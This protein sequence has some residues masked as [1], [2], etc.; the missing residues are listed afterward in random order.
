RLSNKQYTRPWFCKKCEQAIGKTEAEAARLCTRIEE[1][2]KG[3]QVYGESL[4]R[5]ATS[6]SWR[7]LKVHTEREGIAKVRNRWRAYSHW[8]RYLRGNRGGIDRYAQHVFVIT[9][10]VHGLHKA[11]GGR[12]Y[13][14][15]SL[16]LS[17]IGPL[18]IVGQLAPQLLSAGEKVT[19]RNSKI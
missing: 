12:V 15:Q 4:L 13:P 2:P 5:F 1:D 17:Q 18:F 6:I 11:L 14:E 8:Q 7:T 16:V 19:W 10:E 9:D 3:D